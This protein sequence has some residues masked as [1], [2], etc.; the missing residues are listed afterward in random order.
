M[1]VMEQ[2]AIGTAY[3]FDG[4]QVKI[5]DAVR[6]GPAAEALPQG[7][8]LNHQTDAHYPNE[9][10]EKGLDGRWH[11]VANGA[12]TDP[13][14]ILWSV[15]QGELGRQETIDEYRERLRAKVLAATERQLGR[16]D[17]DVKGLL[18]RL[19]LSEGVIIEGSHPN[20][21]KPIPD[22]VVVMAYDPS[23]PDYHVWRREDGR[24]RL[25]YGTTYTQPNEPRQEYVTVAEVPEQ[26]IRHTPN[27]TD[28]AEIAA[29]K[30]QVWTEGWA[31]K[32]RRGWCGAY[33]QVMRDV[34]LSAADSLPDFSTFAETDQWRDL[35]AGAVLGYSG[36]ARW[37]V[38][39]RDDSQASGLRRVAGTS[40]GGLA[41][42]R[43]RILHDGVGAMSI[44]LPTELLGLV[45]PGCTI[46][47]SE[48]RYVKG[49][50]HL[51]RQNGVGEARN[52][53]T[54]SHSD[55]GQG[56]FDLVGFPA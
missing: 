54:L 45:P 1:P 5:G 32:R 16:D 7:S 25:E 10:M 22:G 42:N 44:T 37:D 18:D 40:T 9:L 17:P 3:V 21:A 49:D 39:V 4:V 26:V 33:E 52:E 24:W 53:Y 34:G 6:P 48:D 13:V 20:Y 43:W 41:R 11:R 35:P 19:G 38:A 2:Q 46:V 12:I 47:F 36:A 31:L 55:R 23:S 30:A 15:P 51:W 27:D 28:A 56:S 14:G 8:V 50:D 29:F